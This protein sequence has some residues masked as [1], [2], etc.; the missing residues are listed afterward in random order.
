MLRINK[1][2]NSTNE[3][4]ASETGISEISIYKITDYELL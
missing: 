2:Y 1:F 4:C 3:T